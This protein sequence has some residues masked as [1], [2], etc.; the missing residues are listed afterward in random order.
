[1]A[2]KKLKRKKT[3]TAK[4]SAKKKPKAGKRSLVPKKKAARAPAAETPMEPPVL[5]TPSA[6]FTF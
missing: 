2:A 5:P 6:T 4:A 3:P 1:M